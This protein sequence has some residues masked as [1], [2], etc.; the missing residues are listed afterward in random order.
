M[1]AVLIPV[2]GEI[3]TGHDIEFSELFGDTATEIVHFGIPRTRTM[4][5][6]GDEDSDDVRWVVMLVDDEG[7]RRGRVPNPRATIL[8]R[9]GRHQGVIFGD[10]YLVMEQDLGPEYGRDLVDIEAPY[11]SPQFWQEVV[12]T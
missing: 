2:E 5:L 10:A 9:G 12:T 6:A 3:T 4:Y 8:Y 11:D 1:Q 7:V